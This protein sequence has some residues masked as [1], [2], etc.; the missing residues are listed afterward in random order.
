LGNRN[1]N[2]KL[3][4]VFELQQFGERLKQSLRT[5]DDA[6]FTK[7][8]IAVAWTFG[9]KVPLKFYGDDDLQAGFSNAFIRTLQSWFHFEMLEDFDI[10]IATSWRI[11]GFEPFVLSGFAQNLANGN[12]DEPSWDQESETS[13]PSADEQDSADLDDVAQAMFDLR[14]SPAHKFTDDQSTDIRYRSTRRRRISD[15]I[16]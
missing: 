13:T 16:M 9:G 15:S 4:N 12:L 6:S 11:K 1:S 2:I 10:S 7:G 5:Q 3:L 8:A 14:G